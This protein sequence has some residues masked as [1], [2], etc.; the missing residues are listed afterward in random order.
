LTGPFT[1]ERP[2][3]VLAPLMGNTPRGASGG[4]FQGDVASEAFELGYEAFDLS[5]GV[6]ALVVVAAEV[7]VGFAVGEHMPV[8]DEHRVLHGAEGAAVADSGSEALVLGLEVAVFD[9]GRGERGFLQRDTEDLAAL[10]SAAGAALPGGLV[11]AG[12]A[13]GP[14]L[15]GRRW[16]RRSCRCRSQR[17]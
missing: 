6:A 7:A 14:R 1:A 4:C 9:A 3:S 16:G 12:A 8:G 2:T 15:G 17:P 10:A 11:V 5:F 13:G